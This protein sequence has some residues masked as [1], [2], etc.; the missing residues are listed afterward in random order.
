MAHKTFPQMAQSLRAASA[1]GMASTITLAPDA[2]ATLAD[3][4][5]RYQ[6]DL[7]RDLLDAIKAAVQGIDNTP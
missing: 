4:L 1:A 6:K 7:E 3:M 5:D 2:A